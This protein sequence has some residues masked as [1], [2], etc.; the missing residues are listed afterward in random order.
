MGN[1]EEFCS[2]VVDNGCFVFDAIFFCSS[3]SISSELE[4]VEEFEEALLVSL[5]LSSESNL[6]FSIDVLSIPKEREKRKKLV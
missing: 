1:C 2:A 4:E 3:S 6:N 5:L